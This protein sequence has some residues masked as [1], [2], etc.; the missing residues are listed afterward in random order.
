MKTV[1]I[2]FTQK[3][4]DTLLLAIHEGRKVIRDTEVD[5]N[6]YAKEENEIAKQSKLAYLLDL[7]CLILEKEKQLL[8]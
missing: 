1:R 8:K 2:S 3:Q 6:N 4:L 5:Q 7:Q